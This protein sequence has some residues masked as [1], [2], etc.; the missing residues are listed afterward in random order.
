MKTNP[1]LIINKR[2]KKPSAA[3]LYWSLT[4]LFFLL[5]CVH[6]EAVQFVGTQ[7]GPNEW[8]YTLIYDPGDNYSIC[9]YQ[10]TV[11]LSGLA[12]V[13]LATRPASSDYPDNWVGW[14]Q[15]DWI[16]TIS[17]GGTVVTWTHYGPGTGNWGIPKH[18]YGFKVYTATAAPSGPVNLRTSGFERDGYYCPTPDLDINTTAVGPVSDIDHDLIPDSTDQ[19]SYSDTRETVWI[20]GC[21]SGVSNDISGALAD[22]DGYTLAD[23]IAF[24]LTAAATDAPNHGQFV[25]TMAAYLNV[26]VAAGDITDDEHEAL[27]SCVGATDESQFLV[28]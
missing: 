8:T 15:L 23:Y 2:T 22:E 13:V 5:A 16:P 10:T 27:M 9:Q 17:G 11:R 28:P 20:G 6:T 12:G 18:V 25:R 1:T 19:F 7:T 14:A 4:A 3:P 24:E 26:L 21:D